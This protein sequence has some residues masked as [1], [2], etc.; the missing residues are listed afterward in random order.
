LA[1]SLRKKNFRDRLKNRQ[2]ISGCGLNA[3]FHNQLWDSEQNE[4][5]FLWLESIEFLG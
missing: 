2:A 5:R 1:D 4:P 3:L